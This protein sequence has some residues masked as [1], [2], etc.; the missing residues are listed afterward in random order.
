MPTK[1]FVDFD[2][3]GGAG[4]REGEGLCGGVSLVV[5]GMG[6][7]YNILKGKR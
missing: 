1:D 3:F 5:E 2:T 7:Y 6:H 4:G